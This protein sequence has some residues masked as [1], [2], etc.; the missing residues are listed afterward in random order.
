MK[1]TFTKAAVKKVEE[2]CGKAFSMDAYALANG[3]KAH[4]RQYCNA[5]HPILASHIASKHIWLVPPPMLIEQSIQ[6]YLSCKSSAPE[7]TS[8][9][10]VVPNVSDAPWWHLLKGMKPVLRFPKGHLLL[11]DASGTRKRCTEHMLVYYDAPGR[12]AW[13]PSTESL[14]H[15]FASVTA[16]HERLVMMFA[17]TI[18][19][20]PCTVLFDS[21]ASANIVSQDLAQ[22]LH[23]DILACNAQV[24]CGTGNTESVVGQCT[25]PAVCIQQACLSGTC[26]VTKTLAP[27]FDIIFGCSWLQEHRA[28]LSFQPPVHA[29]VCINHHWHDL[30][31]MPVASPQPV[32]NL[33][34]DNSEQLVHEDMVSFA[35]VMLPAGQQADSTQPLPDSIQRVLTEFAD[36][37]PD[38]LPAG[39]PPSRG[40]HHSIPLVPGSQ[41]PQR[42]S[43]RLSPREFQ[44]AQR[45]I[46]ELMS[47]GL[48]QPS[49][50]PFCSPVL[51]VPK[52]D[53]DVLRMVID[54]RALNRITIPNKYPLPR[55]DQFFEVPA[56]APTA[57]G[58]LTKASLNRPTLQ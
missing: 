50:S 5:D 33:S 57:L 53:T 21:G 26:L 17:A 8:A 34:A 32:I 40:I 19:G 46:S 54:Y 44:E 45:Q 12:P 6:H 49:S 4:A 56:P 47:L 35:A 10:I 18:A 36:V 37:M 30:N 28:T 41:V 3:C 2:Y 25:L 15:G 1:Y 43:Y 14:S 29:R 16:D 31:A 27:D 20:Y 42:R 51:F 39:L 13:Q 24:T 58:E 52:K 23:L 7:T 48:I 9:C 38:Q 55:I 11:E 22:R